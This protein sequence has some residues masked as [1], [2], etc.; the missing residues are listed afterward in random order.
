MLG[1][2]GTRGR[3]RRRVTANLRL[4]VGAA[5]A[6]PEREQRERPHA[7]ADAGGDAAAA[8]RRRAPMPARSGART[9]AATVPP[10]AAAA[11]PAA[12][13]RPL[14]PRAWRARPGRSCA[15]R[16]SSSAAQRGLR[17]RR[18]RRGAPVASRRSWRCMSS[19][20][21]V[22]PIGRTGVDRIL[23]LV[24]RRSR[25]ASMRPAPDE[26]ADG[27]GR[28]TAARGSTRWPQRTQLGGRR[29]DVERQGTAAQRE[30]DV[31]LEGGPRRARGEGYRTDQDAESAATCRPGARPASAGRGPAPRRPRRRQMRRTPSTTRRGAAPGAPRAPAG[32]AASGPSGRRA[33]R[34]GRV[35]SSPQQVAAAERDLGDRLHGEPPA[36]ERHPAGPD[37]DVDLRRRPGSRAAT[38]GSAPG[39]PPPARASAASPAA[40]PARRGPR[41]D[42]TNVHARPVGARPASPPSPAGSGSAP[43]TPAT[44]CPRPSGPR[45]GTRP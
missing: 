1:R 40:A 7:S 29:A 33:G 9:G 36:P 11:G 43:P 17:D 13:P 20:R 23:D 26:Q 22:V 3:S 10:R 35:A 21:A 45:P 41:A 32:G 27:R 16:G 19:Q 4:A 6:R 15:C 18:A 37:V 44:R 14:P 12:R 2:A 25:A 28:L 39:S 42:E 34:R 31:E 8:C 24:D 38:P 5:S 30:L